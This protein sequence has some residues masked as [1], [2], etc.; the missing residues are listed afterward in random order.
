MIKSLEIHIASLPDVPEE[1][2]RE[3]IDGIIQRLEDRAIEETKG[4]P[5]SY[6][7]KTRC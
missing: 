1:E 4:A 2:A 5:V 3:I 7:T 6:L